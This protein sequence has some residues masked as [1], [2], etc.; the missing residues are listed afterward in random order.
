MKYS[1]MNLFLFLGTSFFL[2]GLQ[3]HLQFLP[4]PIPH[5]WFIIVTYYS[6][7]KSLFFSLITNFLHSFIIC[8][9][10][11]LF[12]GLLLILINLLTFF[13]TI[14]GEQF[15]VNNRHITLAVGIGCFS[16]HFFKWCVQCFNHGFFFYP[17]LFQWVSTSLVTLLMA[18][19][20]L[21]VFDKIDKKIHSDLEQV[22]LLKNLRT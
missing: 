20:I 9:F 4:V 5:F 16:F 3:S 11:S 6:F 15:R 2:S 21:S 18:P 14:V 19:F 1:F 12:I 22:E 8:S 7:K 13:F 17:Q 10:T